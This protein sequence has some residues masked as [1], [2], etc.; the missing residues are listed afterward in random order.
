MN[1][2]KIETLIIASKTDQASLNIAQTLIRHDGFLPLGP[3]TSEF[4]FYKDKDSMLVIGDKE[5]IY[6]Q[7]ET[8]PVEPKRVIFVSKHKSAQ[9]QPALTVHATGN[10]T[11]QAKYGGRTEEG[12]W[13]GPSG[14]K[15]TLG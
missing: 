5:C 14:I 1:V 12:S 2:L 13:G 6:V 7:P 3:Q 4:D 15:P 11:S 10:L 8:I 9:E